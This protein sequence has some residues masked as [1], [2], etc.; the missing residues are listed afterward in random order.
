MLIDYLGADRSVLAIASR[1]YAPIHVPRPILDE[2]RDLDEDG[3]REL[4]LKLV[5]PTLDQMAEA[6][7]RTPGGPISYED[8]ICLLMAKDNRWT[9]LTNDGAL[10]SACQA[11]GVPTMWGLRLMLELVEHS[12]L[13][14][15]AARATG[16][17]IRQNN[18]FITEG[19]LAD[20]ERALS[21]KPTKRSSQN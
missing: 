11:E 4:D 2:V 20:F 8:W 13:P 15:E 18:P 12:Y 14:T 5:D 17:T 9:T 19:V 21:S 7:R 3:C 6:G 16:R 10:R 1:S